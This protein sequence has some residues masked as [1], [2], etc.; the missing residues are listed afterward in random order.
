MN[1]SLLLASSLLLLIISCTG[2]AV[3]RDPRASY[4][5]NPQPAQ[6]FN[7]IK[8]KVA[9]LPFFNESPYGGEDLAFVATNEL[10]VELSRT[11]EFIFDF[12]EIA[13]ELK[14]MLEQRL[15]NPTDMQKTTILN[16]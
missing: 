9:L 6:S 4:T 3:K 15:W 10:R 8:K 11:G 14:N 2:P 1:K 5:P 12:S 13:C 16:I 7:G